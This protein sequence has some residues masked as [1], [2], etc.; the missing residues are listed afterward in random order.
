MPSVTGQGGTPAA[1]ASPGLPL[2]HHADAAPAL[3]VASPAALPASKPDD[4]AAWD[5]AAAFSAAARLAAPPA[6]E[7][8]DPVTAALKSAEKA[9]SAREHRRQLAAERHAA[10][11]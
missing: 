8:D 6:S 10:G 1:L 7:P 2:S 9:R 4:S 3:A 11:G 5:A